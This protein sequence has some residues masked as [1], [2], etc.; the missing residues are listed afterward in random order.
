MPNAVLEAMA[1]GLPVA[2]V[3]VGDV[4]TMVCPENWDFI[5]ARDDDAAFAAAIERLLHAPAIR[6]RLGVRNR[7]RVVA[8]FSLPRMLDQY[9]ELFL[10]PAAHS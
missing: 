6:E 3:D 8:E 1:A 4:R 9:C 7:E 10:G 5:V 2:S